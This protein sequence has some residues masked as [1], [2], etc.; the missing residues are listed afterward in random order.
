MTSEPDGNPGRRPPTIELKATE[1]QADKKA[2]DA[3]T[4]PASQRG[5][6]APDPQSPGPPGDEIFRSRLK[7][8][9]VSALVGAVVMAVIVAG[10]WSAGLLP[11]RDAA[12]SPNGT[13]P[14]IA[15]APQA[16]NSADISARLDKIERTIQAQR[17]E[18]ALGNRLAAAEAATKSL[19]D[20]LATQ[21]RRLDDI[22]ATSQS[23]AKQ[24]D[25]ANAAANAA[26]SSDQ[27]NV[28]H[29][30]I[31]A[32]AARLTALESAVKGLSDDVGHRASG[33]DDQAARLTIAAEALRAAVEREVPY[34]AELK[35][36]QA[37]GADQN[38]T[39]TLEPFAAT[40]VPGAATLARE[41]ATLTPALQRA[42]DTVSGETSFLGRLEAHAQQLVR[43]TPVDAPPGNDPPA[44]IARIKFD[45]ARA[46]IGA[47]LNDITALP[48]T[49]RPLAGDWIKQ[50]RAREEAIAASR[51]IAA[52]A[53]AALSK[54]AAP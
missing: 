47:A 45:T 24:A 41:L 34:Q 42:S 7:P 31:D 6:G 43:V 25:A 33:A 8:H 53:L 5:E 29:G 35:A 30:D 37:L 9:A 27:S 14:S 13:A 1:V 23:A 4:E 15:T 48:D 54:P 12:T 2:A 32:L 21:N 26:K 19:A 17:P 16:T 39:A 22:A 49:A 50:A 36:V 3:A 11:W 52:D 18:P 46:D 38:A 10:L 40:G 28:Q 44:V 51:Q 20:L